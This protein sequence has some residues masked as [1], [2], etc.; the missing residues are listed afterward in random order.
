[1]A[2]FPRDRTGALECGMPDYIPREESVMSHTLIVLMLVVCTGVSP[3]QA[4]GRVTATQ[5]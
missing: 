2:P 1:M 4:D 5:Q 3:V